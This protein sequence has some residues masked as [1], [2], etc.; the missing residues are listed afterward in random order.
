M[1]HKYMITTGAFQAGG[2]YRPM[3]ELNRTQRKQEYMNTDQSSKDYVFGKDNNV[4]PGLPSDVNL[5]G[6]VPHPQQH[7]IQPGMVDPPSL[8]YNAHSFTKHF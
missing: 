4:W 6:A 7:T 2:M 8:R 5:P 1:F 3:T